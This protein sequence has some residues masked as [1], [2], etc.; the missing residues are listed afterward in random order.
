MV[1]LMGFKCENRLKYGKC[2]CYMEVSELMKKQFQDLYGF[3]Y[4][5][6]CFYGLCEASSREKAEKYS[7]MNKR[8]SFVF[9]RGNS[10]VEVIKEAK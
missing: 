6:Y 3:N 8:Y 10:S 5:D 2:K 9:G 4:D 7:N 1:W